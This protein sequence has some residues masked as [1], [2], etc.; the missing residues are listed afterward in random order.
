MRERKI[1]IATAIQGGGKTHTT[2][3]A[4]ENYVN[5]NAKTGRAGQKVLIYDVNYEFTNEEIQAKGAN[6]GRPFNFTTSVLDIKD[7]ERWTRQTRPE[8]RRILPVDEN[9]VELGEEGMVQRLTEILKIYRGGMLLL[10]DYNTYL[11]GTS[12]RD[13]IQAITRK[14]HKDIDIYIHLQSLAPI[15]PRLWQNCDVVRFHKQTDEIFRYGDRIPNVEKFY[16]AEK[17]VNLKYESGQTRFYC[18]V[19]NLKNKIWGKF[20]LKE[21][22]VACLSYLRDNPTIINK[23]K[24]RFSGSAKEKEDQ[25]IKY[26]IKDLMKYYGNSV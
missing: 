3:E 19:E 10:E 6:R 15:S 25:A 12:T 18:Y 14:R 13:I 20:S 8:V 4:I 16:I 7:L 1:I 22:W 17:L 2:L 26:C 21:Y 5:Y 9:G 23:A 24:N 11:I